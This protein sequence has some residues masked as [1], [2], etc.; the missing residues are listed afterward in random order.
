MA[1]FDRFCRQEALRWVERLYALDVMLIHSLGG[2]CI[3][4]SVFIGHLFRSVCVPLMLK[5]GGIANDMYG[6]G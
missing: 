3:A 6:M 1:G 5:F 4:Q 2:G